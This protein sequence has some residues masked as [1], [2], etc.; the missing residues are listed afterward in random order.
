MDFAFIQLNK[1]PIFDVS[2][3]ALDFQNHDFKEK[4][5]KKQVLRHFFVLVRVHNGIGIDVG[6]LG[7]KKLLTI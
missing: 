7:G 6:L 2:R 1:Y 5:G 4:R 3:L